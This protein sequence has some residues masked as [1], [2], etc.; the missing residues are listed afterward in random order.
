MLTPEQRTKAREQIEDR[1]VVAAAARSVADRL[2]LV[3]DK[4]GLS[5]DQRQQIAKTHSQFRRQ[6]SAHCAANDWS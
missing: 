4:L 1:I 6:V 5:D 2:E 3:G